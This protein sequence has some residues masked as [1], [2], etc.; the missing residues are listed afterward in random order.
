MRF[1]SN[2]ILNFR[3]Q[4]GR[5]NNKESYKNQQILQRAMEEAHRLKNRSP[6]RTRSAT[7]MHLPESTTEHLL[8]LLKEEGSTP[9]SKRVKTQ[10]K[11]LEL[12]KSI[13]T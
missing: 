8:D 5:C 7:P 13:H 3:S 12:R 11:K 1:V 10:R 9:E 2:V 6:D 4:I